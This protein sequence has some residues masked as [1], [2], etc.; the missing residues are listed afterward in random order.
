MHIHKIKPAH[1]WKEF[2]SEILIIVIGVLIALG[3]EQ[4][5]ESLHWSHEVEVERHSLLAEAQKALDVVRMRQSHQSCIDARLTQIHTL[6]RRHQRHQPLKM[7]HPVEEHFRDSAA[8]GTWQIALTG[9]ALAHMSH[10]ERLAFS[11]A[12]YSYQSW[13]E[14]TKKEVAAWA[15]LTSLGEPDLLNDQDWSRI[16]AA[17][18][19]ARHI[20]TSIQRFAIYVLKSQNLGLRASTSDNDAPGYAGVDA[21]MCRPF[22]DLS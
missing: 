18:W 13:D 2:L 14:A 19:A 10:D 11:S 20:N 4:S 22:V 17:Y 1:G 9:Q 5:V 7:T 16:K 15:E 3:A 6:I 12:F 21:A 8:L